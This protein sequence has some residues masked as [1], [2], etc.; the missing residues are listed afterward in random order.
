M[1]ASKG[2]PQLCLSLL[3]ERKIDVDVQD[4]V[5]KTALHVAASAGHAKVVRM[6]CQQGAF[7]VARTHSGNT[8]SMLARNSAVKALKAPLQYKFEQTE[9]HTQA[10]GTVVTK[11]VPKAS[12]RVLYIASLKDKTDLLFAQALDACKQS[13]AKA[14]EAAL[15]T[16]QQK[17]QERELRAK[18]EAAVAPPVPRMFEQR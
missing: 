11:T 12:T 2:D 13:V 6:L 9:Q 10:D 7:V 5:G 15:A 8:A 4:M 18:A 16:R 14:A 3:T 1:Q 17:V